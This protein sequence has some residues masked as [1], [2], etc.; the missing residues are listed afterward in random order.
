MT[1]PHRYGP[2]QPE[3]APNAVTVLTPAGH[4]CGR[5]QGHAP[6]CVVTRWPEP[7]VRQLP[8]AL[9]RQ[10]ERINQLA[11]EAGRS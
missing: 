11:H 1:A 6:G 8:A 5:E 3:A 4:S 7:E 10:R 2:H 9:A